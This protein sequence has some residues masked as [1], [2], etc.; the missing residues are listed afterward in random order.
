M[1]NGQRTTENEKRK[2]ENGKLHI[3]TSQRPFGEDCLNHCDKYNNGAPFVV[4]NSVVR[5]HSVEERIRHLI[6][7]H[8]PPDPATVTN[9]DPDP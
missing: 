8:P 4:S 6:P 9:P 2:T 7:T 5:T 3:L 1:E